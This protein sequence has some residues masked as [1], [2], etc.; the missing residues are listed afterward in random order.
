MN[1]LLDALN[2]LANV[3]APSLPAP[4]NAGARVASVVFESLTDDRHPSGAVVY[5]EQLLR[6]AAQGEAAGAA[7]YRASKMAGLR[8]ALTTAIQSN[9]VVLFGDRVDVTDAVEAA[10]AEVEARWPE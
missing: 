4:L 3:I 5:R 9:V 8:E 2:T 10:L 1:K 6:I 7:A